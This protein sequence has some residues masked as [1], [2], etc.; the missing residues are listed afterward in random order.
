M[1]P[2]SPVLQGRESFNFYKYGSIK[3]H[4]TPPLFRNR[5]ILSSHML[6]LSLRF[7]QL[8]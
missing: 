8:S 1:L 3:K 4:K 6:F 2:A 5:V 7:K